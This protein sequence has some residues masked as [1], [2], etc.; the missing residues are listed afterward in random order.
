MGLLSLPLLLNSSLECFISVSNTALGI[1][2]IKTANFFS[3]ANK[4]GEVLVLGHCCE[5]TDTSSIM[6]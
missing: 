2:E 6:Q 4:Y 1:V 3:N 5:S